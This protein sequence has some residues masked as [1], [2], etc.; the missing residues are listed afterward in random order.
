[1]QAEALQAR[2]LQVRGQDEVSARRVHQVVGELRMYVERLVGR[3]GPRRRGPDDRVARPRGI[4][5]G[6]AEGARQPVVIREREADVDR[7]VLAVL[8][9]DLRLGQRRAAI[10]APVHRLEAAVDVALLEQPAQRADLVR[11]VAEGHGEVGVVPV[12]QHAEPLE[13]LLLPLDLLGRVG[14]R[15]PLRLRRGDVLAV[16]LL[17]L[18]LDRHAVAVP[19]RHVGRIETRQRAALHDHVLEDLVDRVADVDVAVGVGRAVVQDEARTPAR[20]F[21]DAPVEAARLP[22]GD[23]LGFAL[24]E[25]A[26]HGKRR[27]GQI[28]GVLVV[29]H[30]HAA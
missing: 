19:A 16:L 25:V 30:G 3:Q 14:A 21:A 12:A 24:R 9:L 22:G 10:E 5:V 29:R 6:E 8:V 27:V 18:H 7:D 1:M 11:L 4:Q 28:E 17:D 15:E 26:A 2:L 23:P 13:V 20:G